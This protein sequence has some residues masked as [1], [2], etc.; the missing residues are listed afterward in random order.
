MSGKVAVAYEAPPIKNPNRFLGFV[1]IALA[2]VLG[3]YLIN[4]SSVNLIDNAL[5]TLNAINSGTLRLFSPQFLTFVAISLTIVLLGLKVL[6]SNLW[7]GIKSLLD[8][9]IPAEAPKNLQTKAVID[10]LLDGNKIVSFENPSSIIIKA[11]KWFS[12]KFS[13]I[14]EPYGALVEETINSTPWLIVLLLALAL[15]VWFNGLIQNTFNVTFIYPLPW[16]L[17]Y[18]LLLVVGTR[19]AAC[20]LMRPV[21]PE[22]KPNKES[23]HILEAGNPKNFYN[24]VVNT[25]D[26]LKVGTLPHREYRNVAPTMVNVADKLTSTFSGDVVIETQPQPIEHDTGMAPHLLG[27]VGAVLSM[28]GFFILL[29]VCADGLSLR[30]LSIDKILFWIPKMAVAMYAGRLALIYGRSFIDRSFK[31]FNLYYFSSD[32]YRLSLDGTFTT[33]HIGLVPGSR[34]GGLESNRVA[35]QSDCHV[36]IQ[37]YHIISE[38]HGLANTMGMS[39]ERVIVSAPP[40]ADL[41]QAVQSLLQYV[42]SFKDSSGKLAP[43]DTDQNAAKLIN[44]NA[45]IAGMQ[46]EAERRGATALE[47]SPAMDLL[48]NKPAMEKAKGLV[49]VA[50]DNKT[51]PACGAEILAGKNFCGDCGKDLR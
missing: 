31:L 19:V 26:S 23:K 30:N 11:S 9:S 47:A 48:E 21:T 3:V 46:A 36:T 24:H 28:S 7:L 44:I 38:S 2:V 12:S 35:V 32:I 1:R 51:C 4:W 43:V 27:V 13:T 42:A 45:R 41:D 15:P 20:I 10:N 29:G 16:A 14:T 22:V 50:P 6:I 40:S 39:G 34:H 8:F 17:I 33:S 49:N 37:G 18:V 5:N 25:L